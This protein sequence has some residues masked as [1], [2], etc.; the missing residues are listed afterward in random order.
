[1]SG[2]KY[3]D[4]PLGDD[5]TA[6]EFIAAMKK[7]S[8]VSI[9]V[10]NGQIKTVV[11]NDAWYNGMTYSKL[12]MLIDEAKKSVSLISKDK[13]KKIQEIKT[14]I[15]KIDSDA[16]K[17]KELI[18]K[19]KEKAKKALSLVQ[20][21]F[22]TPFKV[23]N[24]EK[25]TQLIK[26]EIEKL[27]KDLE[28]VDIK[29]KKEK[30]ELENFCE[31]IEKVKDSTEYIKLVK[32]Q[33][34]VTLNEEKYEEVNIVCN[35]ITQKANILEKFTTSIN[36]SVESLQKAGLDKYINRLKVLCDNTDPFS[37]DALN[38][39]DKIM[40]EIYDE[41]AMMKSQIKMQSIKDEALN[42]AE[43]RIQAL[44]E[45]GD[46]LMPIFVNGSAINENKIEIAKTN[47]DIID[48]IIKE[49]E[50]T[51]SFE[52]VSDNNKIVL[53][54]ALKQIE[55]VRS[56]ISETSI[57][58]F[59]KTEYNKV[60]KVV[61]ES[62]EK[63]DLYIQYKKETER[64]NNLI[65]CLDESDQIRNFPSFEELEFA[66]ADIEGIVNELKIMN[67]KIQHE[68]FAIRKDG[69]QKCVITSCE[70]NLVYSESN[71][72]CSRIAFAR[73]DTKGVIYD[74]EINE[75][76]SMAVYPRG[77]ILSNGKNICS[78]EQLKK[79]H[80]SCEWA[81]DLD[82][83]LQGVCL[84]GGNPKEI[85][86]EVTSKMYDEKEFIHLNEEQSK[87]YLVICG[88]SIKECE[89]LGYYGMESYFAEKKEKRQSHVSKK[90]MEIKN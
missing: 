9:K 71:D 47:V 28:N 81:R 19:R 88:Y 27:D 5:V 56:R 24:L 54:K 20:K 72:Q 22:K 73:E 23:F 34:Q 55:N 75:K 68:I 21:E 87:L 32:K 6:A 18:L 42:E 7:V 65:A 61:E 51:E 26:S 37:P 43:K 80:S 74:V 29:A 82:E 64:Y 40:K 35:E 79:A 69:L 3:Y 48:N 45:L 59:L 16:E 1:M 49:I 70:S 78:V 14:K 2:P 33:P 46:A 39:I 84:N 50:K 13:P 77:V 10:E 4:Y 83:A 90:A 66:N 31:K 41:I 38:M 11:S 89:E 25:E 8:G 58:D 44:V 85:S 86:D 53:D 62:K 76:G 52:Y 60:K 63:N 17:Q 15:G 57:N 67:D 12:G 36:K 30:A